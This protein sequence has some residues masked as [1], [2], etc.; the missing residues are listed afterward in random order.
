MIG[1][2]ELKRENDIVLSTVQA[3]ARRISSDVIAVSVLVEAERVELSFWTDEYTDE[4]DEDADDVA[5]ELDALLDDYGHPLIE[6]C[7]RVGRPNPQELRSY[8]RMVY[9]AKD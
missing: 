2:E 1:P 9:W 4:L 7:I 5:F 3:L 6:Y 8:G